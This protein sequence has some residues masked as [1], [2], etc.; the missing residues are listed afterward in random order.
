MMKTI[1]EEL[2]MQSTTKVN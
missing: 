1:Y 2:M